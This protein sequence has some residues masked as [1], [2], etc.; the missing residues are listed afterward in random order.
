MSQRLIV[1]GGGGAGTAAATLAKRF[2]PSLRVTVF[3]EFPD[4]AYSPCG[5][6]FVHGKEIPKFEDLFLSTV[7]RYREDGLDM[8]M[9]TAITDID[10]DRRTVT[11]RN[12]HEGFDKLVIASG[13][14]WEKPTVPGSNLDGLHYVKDIRAA[15]EFDKQLDSMRRAVVFGATPIGIE[16]AGNLGNRGLQVDLVDE[17]P[18]ALSEILDPDVA[19]PVHR[20]LEK[21]GVTLHFGTKVEGFVEGRDGRVGAVQTSR[22]ELPCDVVIVALHKQPNATLAE[23]AGLT[24]GTTGG[25][26]VDEHMRTSARGV[27]AAGDVVEVPH[28]LTMLPIRGLTGAHAYAQGRTAAFDISGRGGVYDPVWIP[29]GMVAGDYT[30]GGFSLGETLATAIGVP[31]V[32]AR[33]VGVS[34]ARYYPG[35]TMTHVKLLAEPDTLKLVGGQIHG[36]EGVK[37]RCDFLAFAAKRG[38]TLEDLAW[39]ENIYSPP[40]GALFEPIAIAAQNGLAALQQPARAKAAA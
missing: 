34:R 4:I 11:A 21:H 12:T 20:S 25:I 10:L 8:R 32:L 7:D 2:D 30:I 9:E 13:F 38:A 3:T 22:G 18:W 16:M 23:A 31:Y 28:G 15:M 14:V 26:M 17:G 6:P 37:E 39:M 19:E 24:I 40:I 27:W 5:M 36:G 33:G 35:A 1:I 29:W